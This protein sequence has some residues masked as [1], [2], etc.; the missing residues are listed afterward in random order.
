MEST[1][2]PTDAELLTRIASGD[3][4]A[5]AEFYDRHH[6]L[7]FGI[8]LK[9]LGAVHE[10][11]D[12]LQDA[13]VTLWERAP[14]YDPRLGSPLAWAATLTRNKAIDRLR[15]QRRHADLIGSAA[16]ETALL[17]AAAPSD[18]S[19]RGAASG[20]EA[21]VLRAALATLSPDQRDALHLGFFCGLT[22]VEIAARLNQPLGTVKAR[23]RRGMMTLRDALE[24]RL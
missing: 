2:P 17:H 24:G 23:M 21:A 6:R 5:F 9:V 16:A 15:T 7:L 10:A 8:A 20:D 12:V 18:D 13:C 3:C 11:E 14:L 19:S 4:G 22:Q 1:V